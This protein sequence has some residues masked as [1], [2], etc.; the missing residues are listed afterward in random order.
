MIVATEI[1]GVEDPLDHVGAVTRQERNDVDV[2]FL[3]VFVGIELIESALQL[4][5]GGFVAGHLRAHK[6]GAQSVELVVDLLASGIER[7]GERRIN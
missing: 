5:V 4:P 3:Q 7:A 2:A 6:A 1:D